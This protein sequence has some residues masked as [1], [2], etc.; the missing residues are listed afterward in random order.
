MKMICV[1]KI[2]HSGDEDQVFLFDDIKKV[3][4]V[5]FDFFDMPE[6]RSMGLD[7]FQNWLMDKDIGYFDV[8]REVVR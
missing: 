2:R 3:S 6:R 8:W 1:L 4:D 7:G 5:V